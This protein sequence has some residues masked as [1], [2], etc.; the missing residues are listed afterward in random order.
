MRTVRQL[1]T[2]SDGTQVKVAGMVY[3]EDQFMR[4]VSAGYKAAATEAGANYREFNCNQD[5]AKETQ[6]INT[7]VQDKIDGIAIAPPESGFFHRSR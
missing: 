5:Q 6:T 7:Y 1:G 4:M 3:L 2:S